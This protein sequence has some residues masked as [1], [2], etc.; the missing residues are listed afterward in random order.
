MADY[1]I[2]YGK[3][4]RHC[5]FKKGVCAN[6]RG[7]PRRRDAEIGDVVQSFLSAKA[8]YREKGRTRKT[9]RLELAIKRHVTGALNG[10]V[11]S[12]AMLPKM[13]AHAIRFGDTGALIVRIANSLPP[14]RYEVEAEQGSMIKLKPQ[15]RLGVFRQRLNSPASNAIISNSVVR[16]AD[17]CIRRQELRRAAHS[18][19]ALGRAVR[20]VRCRPASRTRSCVYGA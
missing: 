4:P 18:G 12:A 16:L 1:E 17:S 20:R 11:G 2:G 19:P 6:P 8:Q 9:S 7:R 3:P 15:D 13:R 10:D 5:Q 14:L